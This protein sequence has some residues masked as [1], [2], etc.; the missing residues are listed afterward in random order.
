MRTIRPFRVLHSADWHLGK[1]LYHK[2]REREFRLF[3]NWLLQQLEPIDLLLIAGD[4]FDTHTPPVWAQELYYQFL[5]QASQYCQIIICAGNHDSALFLEAPRA[6]L[7]TLN[8]HIVGNPSKM[9]EEQFQSESEQNN[10]PEQNY[11]PELIPIYTR[12]NVN[13]VPSAENLQALVCVLPYLKDHYLR[14]STWNESQQDKEY[15]IEQGIARYYRI[16]ANEAQRFLHY[17]GNP[18]VPI[19]AMGHLFASGATTVMDDGVRELYIGSLGHFS[20][21][22]FPADF[23]YVALGHI[24]QNQQLKSAKKVRY[25]GSPLA[26]SFKEKPQKSV[27]Q[28]EFTHKEPKVSEMAIPQWQ[29]MARLRGNAS[30]LEQGIFELSENLRNFNPVLLENKEN[31]DNSKTTL[32]IAWLE[33]ELCDNC[34]TDGLRDKLMELARQHNMEII[35][36]HSANIVK[37]GLSSQQSKNPAE[38]LNELNPNEVFRRRLEWAENLPDD[39]D[40]LT[41]ETSKKKLYHKSLWPLY[42][43]LIEDIALQKDIL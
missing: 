22:L 26:F 10:L 20:G 19:I 32:E 38:I 37:Y 7:K 31:Q 34:A 42:E 23:D 15:K 36:Y 11:L 29:Y 24:H 25:S 3:L 40:T 28:L 14:T 41:L 21:N 5:Y 27:L 35:R 39:S 6:L 4:I 9:L 12:K 1:R 43:S 18:A 13:D 8:V 33:L 17:H 2:S 16:L 30:E